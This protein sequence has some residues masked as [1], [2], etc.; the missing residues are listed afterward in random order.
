M[1]TDNSTK[2]NLRLEAMVS[3]SLGLQR[4]SQSALG[5]EGH[6]SQD[7]D[8]FALPLFDTIRAIQPLNMNAL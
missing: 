6:A 1:S 3:T 7:L 5:G 4:E 2:V 8:G